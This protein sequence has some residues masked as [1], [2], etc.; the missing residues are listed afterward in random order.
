MVRGM[1]VVNN[2]NDK[3]RMLSSVKMSSLEDEDVLLFV[4]L[5][6]LNAKNQEKKKIL[7]SSSL[8]E[9]LKI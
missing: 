8:A 7:N 5:S 9:I 4:P 2:R 6:N 1:R 3:Q